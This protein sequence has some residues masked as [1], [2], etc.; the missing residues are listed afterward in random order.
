MKTAP[1][2]LGVALLLCGMAGLASAGSL[3]QVAPDR[4]ILMLHLNPEALTTDLDWHET[5]VAKQ[6]AA[7]PF[8]EWVW[9]A[10]ESNS[11]IKQPQ[12]GLP[13]IEIVME[14]LLKGEMLLT[15]PDF[16]Q[17]TEFSPLL[18]VRM[19]VEDDI[20]KLLHAGVQLAIAN[21]PEA[22]TWMREGYSVS[23]IAMGG[24]PMKLNVA[25]MDDMIAVG[26][27]R[28]SIER[29]LDLAANQADGSLAED[30]IV[31]EIERNF[32]DQPFIG[33]HL[34]IARAHEMA[35]MFMPMLAQ[36][37]PS[38][39][40]PMVDMVL[41]WLDL[42]EGTSVAMGIGDEGLTSYSRLGLNQEAS[43]QNWLN[44]WQVEPQTFG[45]MDF[46][47]ADASQY[48][49]TNLYDLNDIWPMLQDVVS[50]I[51][52]LQ[53]QAPQMIAQFEQMTG[54]D[55]TEDVFG[56]MGKETGMIMGAP[57]MPSPEAQQQVPSEL[58][59]FIETENPEHT[60]SSFDKLI[61]LARGMLMAQ[62]QEGGPQLTVDTYRDATI[63]S[64]SVPVPGLQPA[65]AVTQGYVLLSPTRSFLEHL[66]DVAAG[67]AESIRENPRY[68][69]VADRIPS[70]TN[71][72][73]FT[74]A[75]LY[76][77]AYSEQMMQM[78]SQ[79][80]MSDDP[81]STGY[82]G[83]LLSQVAQLMGT[84]APT[85]GASVE[86]IT[87]DGHAIHN[88]GL[89]HVQDLPEVVPVEES[90]EVQFARSLSMAEMYLKVGNH[91]KALIYS[92]RALEANP[93]HWKALMTHATILKKAG[94]LRE[95]RQT[96]RRIGFVEESFWHI[97][98]PFDNTDGTGYD[99]MYPPEESVD[100]NAEL[101]GV[102]GPVQWK[103]AP[104]NDG[105]VEF[106]EPYGEKPWVVAYAYTE[107]F[108]DVEREVQFR[109]GTDD[110]AKL[111]LNDELVFEF[112]GGRAAEP[113]QDTVSVK[114]QAGA[115]RTLAKVCN[116]EMKWALY[117]RVTD[118]EGNS[119]LDPSDPDQL[120]VRAD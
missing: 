23:E 117:L 47:P 25:V 69:E 96:L 14:H 77:D 61:Q 62:S 46:V 11:G 37:I 107:I 105:R 19:N 27:G 59:L 112:Q 109:I 13:A 114:L 76:M 9:A 43:S 60:K 119:V 29:T 58:A 87:A 91:S 86:I 21:A 113:D 68:Q 34:N 103:I 56:W 83:I 111:W 63:Y 84:L 64:V 70:Q 81:S 108:S 7:A 116:Q 41:G 20:T 97:T 75:Y 120:R 72:F 17:L 48:S 2:I 79:V 67:A 38:E 88:H 5:N 49:V 10:V 31:K 65:C 6:I 3:T 39:Q 85:M 4:P 89:L 36:G 118:S 100:L 66:L 32:P 98:G 30:V 92:E 94:S 16:E 54:M 26:L 33:M 40:R 55:V 44:M 15:V 82:E 93:H 99:A 102:D 101:Q 71:G 90:P 78:A 104:G 8:W 24:M 73:S 1:R 18:L 95:A 80:S 53:Q 74:D 28:S 110:D 115:N 42:I 35:Q 12:L 51:P 106:S 57:F 45:S 50:K 52:P 22:G